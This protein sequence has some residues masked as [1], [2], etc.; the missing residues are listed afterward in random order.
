MTSQYPFRRAGTRAGEK[1][2]P[3]P[4]LV[5]MLLDLL[6]H[7]VK[8]AR[9]ARLSLADPDTPA[10]SV[11]ELDR[12]GGP[13]QRADPQQEVAVSAPLSDGGTVT[14]AVAVDGAELDDETS[15]RAQLGRFIPPMV[16][17]VDLERLL[18]ERTTTARDAVGAIERS[19]VIDLATGVVMAR[20]NCDRQT[21]RDLLARWSRRE[22]ID[23]ESMTVEDALERLTAG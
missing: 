2:T 21:A 4:H 3:L 16:A 9:G 12:P 11:G 23:L 1:P 14:L 15:T 22:G 13:E 6:L 8:G 5:E 10:W 19:A 7:D 20:R 17:C 18:R